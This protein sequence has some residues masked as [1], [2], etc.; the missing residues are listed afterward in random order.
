MKLCWDEEKRAK[1]LKERG[2]DFADC[3]EVFA[4][5]TIEY[6]DDRKDYGEQRWITIGFLGTKLVV[7]V[8][9]Q[10]V[11]CTRIIS[12]RRAERSERKLYEKEMG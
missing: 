11:D 1:T 7:I 6:P 12:M 2:L 9:T 4:G 3:E 10:R 8:S 5:P